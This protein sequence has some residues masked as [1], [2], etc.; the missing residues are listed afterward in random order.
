MRSPK[1]ILFVTLILT[2]F[3]QFI[4][5]ARADN[6]TPQETPSP[7]MTTPGSVE[8][9]ASETAPADS[10]TPEMAQ[11]AEMAGTLTATEPD[12]KAPYPEKFLVSVLNIQ[13]A[14]NTGAASTSIPIV[15]PPGRNGIAPNLALTYNSSAGNGQIGVG[16][17]LDVGSI[18]RNA[19]NGLCYT[20]NDYVA[21]INGSSSELVRR[22][23]WDYTGAECYGEKIERSFSKYCKIFASDSW[24]VTTKNGTKYYYG[25]DADGENVA[26]QW[27]SSYGTY[28]WCLVR[29][30]DTNSNY[31][32]FS[33][34]NII[35]GEKYLEGIQYTGNYPSLSPSNSVQ[36]EYDNDYERADTTPSY[37]LIAE[38]IR[39]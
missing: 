16:W 6:I 20:C 5:D 11:P 37:A 25:S 32:T 35:N 1:M 14:G 8:N 30:Q 34:S 23:D 3:I 17:S 36:F 33:Y 12:D 7:I 26:R 9:P 24:V 38:V 29:V 13:P 27:F 10:A 18:Q 19:K 15:V 2:F 22:N 28:K 4:S 21:S 31:M 39:Q